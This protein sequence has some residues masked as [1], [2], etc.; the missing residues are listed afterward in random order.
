[1]NITELEKLAKAVYSPT[2]DNWEMR[3]AFAAFN[4]E[5]NPQTIIQ[6][7]E[8]LKEMAGAL[9]DVVDPTYS[10]DEALAKYEE[11]TK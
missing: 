6:L 4:K 1:V 10:V 5:A 2:K 3:H 9:E 11:M 8:L 7:I